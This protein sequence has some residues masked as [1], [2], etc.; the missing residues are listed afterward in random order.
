MSLGLLQ[1]GRFWL[2]LQA[3]HLVRA[4]SG[5]KMMFPYDSVA[6]NG[7][8]SKMSTGTLPSLTAGTSEEMGTEKERYR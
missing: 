7:S 2:L 1:L 5:R 3:I 6:F 8:G 4:A